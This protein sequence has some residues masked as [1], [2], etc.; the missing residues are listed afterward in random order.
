MRLLRRPEELVDRARDLAPAGRVRDLDLELRDV[1][2]AV[3]GAGALEVIEVREDDALLDRLARREDPG[4]VHVDVAE[5][6]L[7]A[8]GEALP[9][10]EPAPD[11]G[12]VRLR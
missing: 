1:A 5:P 11:E 6:E 3:D 10:R 9:R 4:D 7:L 8:D 2:D 12:G